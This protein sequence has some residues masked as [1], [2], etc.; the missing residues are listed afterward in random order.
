M[1]K[2]GFTLIEL[3]AV[4]T[5]LGIISILIVPTIT[6]VIEKT[7]DN[8]YK[9]QIQ[10]IKSAMKNWATVNMKD[11]PDTDGDSVSLILGDLKQGGFLDEK[12]I[13]PKTDMCF[14]NE[15]ELIITKY[16]NNYLFEV[17][18]LSN[19]ENKDCMTISEQ[20]EDSCFTFDSATKTITDYDKTC[21]TDVVIPSK[22]AGVNVENI[23]AAAFIEPVEQYCTTDYDDYDDVGLSYVKDLSDGYKACYF[24]V[25]T[26]EQITSVILPSTLKTIGISAFSQN[27]LTNIVIPE[28]VTT[29]AEEAFFGNQI[30]EANLPNTLTTL[31]AWAFEENSLSSITIPGSII[32]I[33]ISAFSCNQL[34]SIVIQP[35]VE[36]IGEYAF[37]C[38]NLNYVTIPT[39]VE[40]IEMRAFSDNSLESVDISDTVNFIGWYAFDHNAIESLVIPS[41]VKTISGLAFAYNNINDLIIPETVTNIGIA[42]FNV[43]ELPDDQAFIYKRNLDGSLNFTHLMSYGGATKTNVTIPNTVTMIDNFAFY[44]TFMNSITL[45]N[46]LV[47]IGDQAFAYN[48]IT[49]LTIPNSVL[50]IS[51]EAF[52]HNKLEIVNIEGKTNDNDFSFYGLNIWG[53]ATGFEDSNIIWNG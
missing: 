48:S 1:N 18:E 6:R 46:N 50:I 4:V 10:N 13:N 42:A 35:G 7:K 38:N 9:N 53:W 32:E 49:T 17:D 25:E 33:G 26:S 19:I 5:I 14:G 3:L 52:L 29:I 2:K 39:G 21:G 30:T 44:F 51:N 40:R 24:E 31:G 43:N 28:G 34:E 16:Q 41:G 15:T 37:N 47:A 11:L 8:A 12:F 36:I 45:S 22:I 20:I 23:G 27:L